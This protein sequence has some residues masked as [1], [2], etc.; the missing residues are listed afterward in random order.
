[1]EGGVTRAVTTHP[2]LPRKRRRKGTGRGS[3]RP[4]DARARSTPPTNP[5]RKASAGPML[6]ASPRHQRR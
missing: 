1:M 6:P 3:P 5:G 2:D 4:F